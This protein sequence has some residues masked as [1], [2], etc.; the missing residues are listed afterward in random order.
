MLWHLYV[1]PF[2]GPIVCWLFEFA[3]TASSRATSI[4]YGRVP[5]LLLLLLLLLLVLVVP[6]CLA[7]V[8]V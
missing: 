4:S 5:L 2:G 1:W 6:H 8:A 7:V 3:G